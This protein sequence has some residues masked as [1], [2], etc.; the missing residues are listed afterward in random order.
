M[1]KK[2]E[3]NLN[4]TIQ[5]QANSND[6]IVVS[7]GGILR[8]LKKYFLPWVIVSVMIA[9]MVTGVATFKTL[10]DK[11]PLTALIS[12]NYSGIENGKDP[13]GRNFDINIVKNSQVIADSL[14]KNDVDMEKASD[15]Q[16]NIT[17]EG[18][19]PQ[20]AI[21]KITAYKSVYETA[22]SG[23][24]AAAQAMLDVTFYPTQYKVYFDYDQCDM[25]KKEAVQVFND[26][27]EGFNDYFYELYGYNKTLG[28]SVASIDY[29]SYDYSEAVD[30]F[31]SNLKI[32]SKYVK[33]LAANDNNQFR[34]N[35]T[36]LTFNDLAQSISTV[37]NLDLDKISSYISVNNITKDKEATA[38]Y[39]QYRI[40]SLNRE[41]DALTE[42]LATLTETIGSYQKDN[43]LIM[44]TENGANSELTTNSGE[45]DKLIERKDSVAS[46]LAETKQSIKYYEQR[47]E[48]L[49]KA[50]TSTPAMMEKV[51]ADFEVLNTRL[52]KLIED[53]QLTAEEYYEIVEFAHAYNIL[54]PPVNSQVDVVKSI[55]N[56]AKLRLVIFEALA[57]LIYMAI[58]FVT[59]I[60]E[61]NAKTV[62]A[63][64]YDDD[65]D[66]DYDDDIDE[67]DEDDTA[68]EDEEEPEKEEKPAKKSSAPNK[69]KR[70]K[71]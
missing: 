57:F 64:D 15:V 54:V 50:T 2:S 41:K 32:L 11:P 48:G 53:T 14:T 31:R 40:D 60:K 21:D 43:I 70:R 27:L 44:A 68:E 23:N 51:E 1:A 42:R 10:R 19:I 5:N 20:D 35:K 28:T 36:G 52:Q 3:R 7:V 17:F 62:F 65:D 55:I 38:A 69:N 58:A 26:I 59:S 4:V 46:D 61:E 67:D 56:H 37:S 24:L 25:T 9:V 29:K 16:Q 18:I 47:K 66:D 49:D 45:Y 8:K 12:F 13:A 71:K 39:Y 30:L 63:D 33:G 6:E 34:S 22:N